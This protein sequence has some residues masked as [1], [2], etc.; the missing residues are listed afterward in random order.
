M[1][2]FAALFAVVF[3]TPIVVA[4]RSAFFAEVPKGSGLYGGGG[5][6][7]QFV[8]LQNFIVAA[9]SSAFWSGTGRVVLYAII[10]IPVMIG[11]ALVLA[12]LLDSYLVRRV[13]FFR[14]AYFLPFAIP[15]II[16]AM[17]PGIAKGRK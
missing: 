7:E 8:G 3:V 10:Q 5:L 17:M 4:V 9:S 15:G 13:G 1:A 14:L 2:P 6:V 16:A 11:L 12:L